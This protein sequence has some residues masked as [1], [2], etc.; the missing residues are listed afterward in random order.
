MIKGEEMGNHYWEQDSRF[1]CVKITLIVIHTLAIIF[2]VIAT[3]LFFAA[4]NVVMDAEKSKS[5]AYDVDQDDINNEGPTLPPEATM[6]MV[7]AFMGVFLAVCLILEIIGLIGII[8]ENKTTVFVYAALGII[9]T[10]N[11]LVNGI[12]TGL[13]S[14]VTVG[15]T[16]YYGYMIVK[17]ERGMV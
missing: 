12:M 3:V 10:I 14:A 1:R 5:P 6:K 8:K 7:G 11:N 4:L 16:A 9:G 13:F 17:R 2:L 15:L